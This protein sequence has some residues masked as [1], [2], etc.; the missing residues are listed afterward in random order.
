MTQLLRGV[1][2]AAL[3]S[4]LAAAPV[5]AHAELEESDPSDGETIITPYTLTAT[6]SEEFDPDRS[7]I[8]IVDESGTRVAEGGVSPDAP[9][10]MVVEL[11]ELPTGQYEVRWQTTTPDDN[12]VERGTYQFT[13][14]QPAA[15]T[16]AG[17]T[18][19]PSVA[20]T[21]A[22][23][24]SA[25]PSTMAP[26]TARSTSAPTPTPTGGGQQTASGNDI[27]LALALAAIVL[28]GL[29]VYLFTRRR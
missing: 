4:L 23:S 29:G 22:P 9:T 5:Y 16:D 27:L 1:V 2:I 10:M 19:L 17:F 18:H 28:L 11:P 25:S 7:F 12:G 20:P 21:S 13:V 8:R 24:A 26:P 15:N 6:F 3:F 14:E